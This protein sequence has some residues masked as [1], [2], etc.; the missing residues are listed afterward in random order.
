MNVELSTLTL[1]KTDGRYVATV[2][3]E[4]PDHNV[5]GCHQSTHVHFDGPVTTDDPALSVLNAMEF[6]TE[7]WFELRWEEHHMFVCGLEGIL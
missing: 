3:A 4:I 7:H 2:C 6:L 1:T 5:P